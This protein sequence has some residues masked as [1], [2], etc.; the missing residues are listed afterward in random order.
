M[1][2]FSRVFQVYSRC[3]LYRASCTKEHDPFPQTN[4]WVYIKQFSK[5]LKGFT[6]HNSNFKHFMLIRKIKQFVH[7]LTHILRTNTVVG[8]KNKYIGQT[9]P[10]LTSAL[11]RFAWVQT[12]FSWFYEGLE[13]QIGA[14]KLCL[15]RL[16]FRKVYNIWLD[17]KQLHK[18]S[19]LK[20]MGDFN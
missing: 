3:G 2:D 20:S 4:L 1:E 18:Y 9:I 16:C 19:W 12:W 5:P 8:T 10:V 14:W 11:I 13:F 6:N 15:F 17:S 7:I